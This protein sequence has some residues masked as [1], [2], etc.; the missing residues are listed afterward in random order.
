MARIDRLDDVL[1]IPD[2]TRNHE[3]AC[4]RR[5][6]SRNPMPRILMRRFLGDTRDVVRHERLRGKK[7]MI[8][9]TTDI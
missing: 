4:R 8:G 1:R 5:A 3:T 2:L 6:E 9:L 7:V